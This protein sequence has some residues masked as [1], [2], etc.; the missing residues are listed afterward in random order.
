MVLLGL[1][2]VIV[3]IV[4]EVPWLHLGLIQS[5]EVYPQA[6][7]DIPAAVYSFSFRQSPDWTTFY[8]KQ[9]EL[10]Q[11]F[12]KVAAE[13]GLDKKCQIKTVVREARF[14]EATN[15][16]HVA[17]EELH[18]EKQFHYVCKLFVSAVGGLSNPKECDIPDYENFKGPLFRSARWDSSVDLKGKNVFVVGNGCSATQFVPVIAERAKML[19]QGENTVNKREKD[20]IGAFDYCRLFLT[21]VRAKHWYEKP[22][23]NP[24]ALIPGW[25]WLIKHVPFFM[26]LQR[27]LIWVVLESHFA[28]T[29]LNIFGRI[30][31]AW[32][33]YSSIR[34]AKKLAPKKY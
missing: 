6:A 32:W 2:I 15:L 20:E 24:F 5:L 17:A 3:R 21:A 28:I 16:W 19:T 33:T 12:N 8:P 18:T 13:F 34:H 4:R 11:Y 26:Y 23:H 7:C 1:G 22:P 31:R 9:A 10:K 25:K 29:Q 27:F 30:A 14:D